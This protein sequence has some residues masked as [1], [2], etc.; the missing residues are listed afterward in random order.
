ME[1]KLNKVN[2]VMKTQVKFK[3]N[4]KP[5]FYERVTLAGSF[6]NWKQIP[7]KQDNQGYFYYFLN[8]EDGIYTYHFH[9]F[10]QQSLLIK[11]EIIDNAYARN[12][13]NHHLIMNG[14]IGIREGD[15]ILDDIY[16]PDEK[17]VALSSMKNKQQE[18]INVNQDLKPVWELIAEEVH[19]QIEEYLSCQK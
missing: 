7:M 6:N 9:L 15:K 10:P 12:I 5:Q 4:L 11:S 8:L 3:L 16:L 17:D 19:L 1:N 14:I 2:Y 13:N 18:L